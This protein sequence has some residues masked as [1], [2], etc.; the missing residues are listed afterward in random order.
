MRLGISGAPFGTAG[1]W[2]A[3]RRDAGAPKAHR[4]GGRR[5]NFLGALAAVVL[6]FFSTMPAHS[7][8]TA[9]GRGE[10]EIVYL[11]EPS[12][13]R[14]LAGARLGLADN[15]GTG[16]FLGQSFRLREATVSEE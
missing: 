3:C 1:L 4:P 7:A 9:P 2:P 8:E 11:S 14:A 6:A 10:V 12:Q 16:R 5:G 15:N 13:Q